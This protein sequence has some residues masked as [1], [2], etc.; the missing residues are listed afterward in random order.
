MRG[1]RSRLG[2]WWWN[3]R[4]GIRS[5]WYAIQDAL[6]VAWSVTLVTLRLRDPAACRGCGR[7]DLDGY[8]P[9]GVNTWCPG[10]CP[11]HN[12]EY[13]RDRRGKF[14]SRCG[15]PLPWDLRGS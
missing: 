11:D 2:K 12:F 8:D 7:T 13:D 1:E 3:A 9:R 15:E 14:C 5:R 10:C 6:G 4:W